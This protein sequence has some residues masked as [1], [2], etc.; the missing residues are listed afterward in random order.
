[1]IHSTVFFSYVIITLL[2]SIF[3]CSFG[4]PANYYEDPLIH[5]LGL[6]P[7][8]SWISFS[9]FSYAFLHLSL[10]W[11]VRYFFQVVFPNMNFDFRSDSPFSQ[12]F[13]WI[14]Q[15]WDIFLYK[16]FVC[17]QWHLSET[18]CSFPA[19][20]LSFPPCFFQLFSLMGATSSSSLKLLSVIEITF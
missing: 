8:H 6:S 10:H 4:S 19:K 15:F 3:S 2:P 5:P 20:V 12:T 17:L 16:A 1:M 13:H 9:K 7:F 14:F 11:F 18:E